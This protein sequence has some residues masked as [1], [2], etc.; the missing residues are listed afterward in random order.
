MEHGQ[1]PGLVQSLQPIIDNYGYLA[2]AFLLFVEDFGV[3]APGET[4]LIAAAFFAG[5]GQLNI[6]IVLVVAFAAA[7]LGDNV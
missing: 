1:L 3:P 5:L 4:T 6:F 7:V 2:V